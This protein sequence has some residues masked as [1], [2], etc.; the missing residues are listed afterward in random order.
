MPKSIDGL[1]FA[2][3]RRKKFSKKS[4][5]MAKQYF[6]TARQGKFP[7]TPESKLTDSRTFSQLAA[8]FQS[9]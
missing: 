2:P 7:L 4:Y 3:K 8:T 6:C 9:F 5:D 1:V